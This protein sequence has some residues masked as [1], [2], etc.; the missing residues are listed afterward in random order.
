MA[1]P[2]MVDLICNKLMLRPQGLETIF[3]CFV[4]WGPLNTIP[5]VL[6]IP[7][8]QRG[9]WGVPNLVPLFFSPAVALALFS[10]AQ[11]PSR[12]P[13]DLARPASAGCQPYGG[14]IQSPS[15]K[16]L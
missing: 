11:P 16:H 3:P 12:L 9:V 14:V 8:I 15:A 10:R 1:F 7:S 2:V 13:P 6:N 4:W 5:V